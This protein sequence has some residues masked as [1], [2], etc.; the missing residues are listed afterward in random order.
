MTA[1]HT[2]YRRASWRLLFSWL[3]LSV[4]GYV[5]GE[6]LI[7][8]SRPLLAASIGQI[9]PDLHGPLALVVHQGERH[10][11]FDAQAVRP[12]ALGRGLVVPAGQALPSS[13]SVF[14][15]LVPLV[16]LGT[17]IG[18]W[19]A[20]SAAEQIRVVI[21][22]IAGAALVLALT[23]PFQ[24]VG[25][26]ELALAGVRRSTRQR[27]PAPARTVVDAHAGRWGT[28]GPPGGSGGA[29]DCCRPQPQDLIGQAAPGRCRLG[30]TGKKP[31]INE[32]ETRFIFLPRRPPNLRRA[33]AGSRSLLSVLALATDADEFLL[34][35][36]ADNLIVACSVLRTRSTVPARFSCHNPLGLSF[37]AQLPALHQAAIG[38]LLGEV[39]DTGHPCTQDIRFEGLNERFSCSVS[40]L[41][42]A[43][44][45]PPQLACLVRNHSAIAQPAVDRFEQALSLA[46]VAWFERDLKTDI[47]IGS[48][49]L[50]QI[51]GLEHPRGPW[52]FNEVRARILPEDASRHTEEIAAGLAPRTDD[53]EARVINY[54]IRR[55][56]GTLRHLEVRYRNLHSI[57]RPRTYGLVFDVTEAKQIEEQLLESTSWL[58]IALSSAG[59]LLWVHDFATGQ[60]RT[61]SNFDEFTGLDTRRTRWHRDALLETVTEPGRAIFADALLRWSRG[62]SSLRPRFSD[63]ARRRHAALDRGQQHA[64]TGTRRGS[65]C[66][67]SASAGT[68]RPKSNRSLRARRAMSFCNTLPISCP[69]RSTSS[70]GIPRGTTRFRT[71]ATASATSTASPL[72]HSGTARRASRIASIRTTSR[73]SCTRCACPPRR[74]PTGNISIGSTIRPAGCAG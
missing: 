58:N 11:R 73:P 17:L 59:I 16:I 25:L 22:G 70:N 10:L 38:R 19:P 52:H 48:P 60:V 64:R 43:A 27:P 50:A 51:Y 37:V 33:A 2:D 20:R 67:W 35:L 8:F 53:M 7:T 68:S 45:A 62:E 18:A 41:A 30:P 26:I 71:R 74:R 34:T 21:L 3:A 44:D 15:V 23:T 65:R 28:L 32:D 36:D 13:A 63:H 6:R 42:Q 47:G 5:A 40:V 39:R 72:K 61:S 4:L 12:I 24:L 56:D 9:A 49:S 29:R 31:Y 69:A 1:A 55:P 57:E 46:R 66:G 14:H 54:R